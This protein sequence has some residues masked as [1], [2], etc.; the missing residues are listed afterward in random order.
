MAALIRPRLDTYAS[1]PTQ[2]SF[3]F[4]SKTWMTKARTRWRPTHIKES[5]RTEGRFAA[6]KIK[7]AKGKKCSG[8]SPGNFVPREQ[9]QREFSDWKFPLTIRT[10]IRHELIDRTLVSRVTTRIARIQRDNENT[11]LDDSR[12][13]SFRFLKFVRCIRNILLA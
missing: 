4:E 9:R 13:D 1:N 6:F 2:R 7:V 8:V 10:S 11:N 12:S 3:R 5:C